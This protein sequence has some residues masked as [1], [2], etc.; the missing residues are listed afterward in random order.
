[1]SVAQCPETILDDDDDDPDDDA[2]DDDDDEDD[3]D[4]DDD[5]A[6][7]VLAF[8]VVVCGGPPVREWPWPACKCTCIPSS[9]EAR[10]VS[11]NMRRS[12]RISF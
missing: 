7:E 1:M 6:G 2:D 3:G 10:V 5:D 9:G 8:G 4:D 11:K 12:C